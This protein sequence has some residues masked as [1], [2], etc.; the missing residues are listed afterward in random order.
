[1]REAGAFAAAFWAQRQRKFFAGNRYDLGRIRPHLGTLDATDDLA[2]HL[3]PGT[4]SVPVFTGDDPAGP[5]SAWRLAGLRALR[6]WPLRDGRA[7]WPDAPAARAGLAARFPGLLSD[8]ADPDPTD[9]AALLRL[10]TRGLAAHRLQRD[11]AGDLVVDVSM[12]AGLPVRPGHLPLGA[13]LVVD[14]ARPRLRVG[15]AE[16]APGDAGWPAARARF[17]AS[18][19]TV[20]TGVDHLLLS[21]LVFGGALV[22]ALRRGTP[23]GHPLRHALA[24]FTFNLVR[25]NRAALAV[26]FGEGRYLHRLFG[27]TWAAW[28]SLLRRELATLTLHPV[29]Q[30]L[31]DRG[32]APALPGLPYWQE[33]LGWAAALQ[34][35]ADRLV[36]AWVDAPT[37]ARLNAAFAHVHPALRGPGDPQAAVARTLGTLLFEG[38]IGHRHVGDVAPLVQDPR[39]MSPTHRPDPRP[40]QGDRLRA[41]VLSFLSTRQRPPRFADDIA[42]TLPAGPHRAHWAALDADLCAW[43]AAHPDARFRRAL[44]ATSPAV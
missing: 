19:L 2:R 34:R 26:L 27:L 23:A 9:A 44:V 32:L 24:P 33:A 39:W 38:T 36:D 3:G 30:R 5:L 41:T 14:A 4:P 15:D 13:T 29:A 20:V 1:M 16:L 25:M 10:A 28:A 42:A 7:T 11:A 35:H 22:Y 17:E 8:A 37:A 40:H 12:L 6:H 43:E 31:A 21:H 18:L